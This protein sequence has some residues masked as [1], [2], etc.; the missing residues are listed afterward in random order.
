MKKTAMILTGVAALASSGATFRTNTVDGLV[1]L[2]KTYNGGGHVIELE[3]GDYNL[4]DD[5]VWRTDTNIHVSHLY[6]HGIRIKGVG[7]NPGDTRLVGSGSFRV[8]EGTATATIENLTVTNGFAETATGYSNSGRGGGVYGGITVTNCLVIGNYARTFG[9]GGAGSVKFEDSRLVNNE[10]GNS[11]GAFHGSSAR[12]TVM[13]GNVAK[14]SGGGVY[15]ATLYDCEV[16]SN[17]TTS[18]YGG[19]GFNV[20]YAT[21]CLFAFN[22]SADSGNGGG[23]GVSNGGSADISGNILYDCSVV[24]NTSAYNAGGA[25]RVTLVGGKILGNSSAKAAGGALNCDIRD[26]HIAFNAANKGSGGGAYNCTLSN[27]TVYANIC[28]NVT[29]HSYGGGA[30]GCTAYDCEI[31]ANCARSCTGTDGKTKVGTAGGAHD[32]D[33]YGCHIHDNYSDSYGGGVRACRLYGCTLENN[34]AGN[35][36]NNAHSSSLVDCDVSGSGVYSGSALGTVFHDIGPAVT[37]SGNPYPNGTVMQYNVWKG[38]IAATNCLFRDNGAD[39]DRMYLYQYASNVQVPGSFVNCTVVSNRYYN[40]FNNL[41]SGY[42]L[43]VGNSVFYGNTDMDGTPGDISVPELNSS[44]A[45]QEGGLYFRNCAY[46]T[47]KVPGGL[48]MYIDGPM[49]RFGVDGFPER[50]G[51]AYGRDPEHPYSLRRSSPLIGKGAYADWMADAADL[52]GDGFARANGTSVDIGCYQCWLD[53]VGTVF[54][55]R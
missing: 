10:A 8:I 36:G 38:A 48:E 41:F 14:N 19:G 6:A 42:P 13:I 37:V 50:P 21:N 25:F 46:G 22:H 16:I 51:F 28:S 40:L 2:L 43:T 54:S 20:M 32:C 27:C 31:Y 53:P 7:E 49:H 26:C 47:A 44:T 35:D 55:I 4:R 17:R 23:G 9:G 34:A 5:L 45:C 33:L 12:S 24:S 52:R 29:D 15:S 3:A 18:S 1:H 30:K 11:G 39:N